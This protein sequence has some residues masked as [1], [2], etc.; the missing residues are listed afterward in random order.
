M[1]CWNERSASSARPVASNATTRCMCARQARLQ[2]QGPLGKVARTPSGTLARRNAGRGRSASAI[3]ARARAARVQ[4]RS[5]HEHP[6]CQRVG[7][8]FVAGQQLQPAQVVAVCLDV[9]GRRPCEG[10]LGRQ[11]L[12]FV[13][14]NDL[15]SDVV[16]HAAKMSSSVRSR[17]AQTWTPVAPSTS[18]AVIR[19]RLP[20]LTRQLQR[21]SAI[22][23]KLASVRERAPFHGS[24]CRTFTTSC[25]ETELRPVSGPASR[26]G[27]EAKVW[28]RRGARPLQLGASC[29]DG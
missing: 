4:I 17:S 14:G 3:T 8:P 24:R 9:V 29:P 26:S 15:V 23:A 7:R 11:Q 27:E 18:R 5:S 2:L 25:H 13:C 16:L 20:A 1:A 10:V 12:D 21:G 22:R 28:E 6:S 19:I